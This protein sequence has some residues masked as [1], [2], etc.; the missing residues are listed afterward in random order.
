MTNTSNIRNRAEAALK[1]IFGQDAQFRDGQYEAI[2]ATLTHKRTLVV[3]RT[4]WGK[5]MV[6]FICTRL[7][8]EESKGVTLIVSPLLSLMDNQIA[9]AEKAGLN[10]RILNSKVS[11]DVK[12]DTLNAMKNGDI[13][14]VFT[15]PETLFSEEVQNAVKQSN[16]ALLVIDEAHCISDWGHDFRL[17][18]SRLNKVVSGM[19][20]NVPVL[21]TTATA[22]DRVVADLR[23]QLGGDVFVS[24][25]ALSRESLSIQVLNLE[26]KAERYA[27]ILENLNKLPGS[28]IIYC[29][30]QD[31]CS[32][33]TAFLTAN[34]I[35][36]LPYHNGVSQQD[37]DEAERL[38]FNNRI[39]VLVATV[40][41]GMGYDKSD[42]SFIIHYQ[43]PSNI[44]SYYQQIGRAG[45]NI[46]RAY[47]FLMY[48]SEDL[49]I[50]DFFIESAFPTKEESDAVMD[51]ITSSETALSAD[52]MAL[53]VNL[54]ER[55]ISKALMFLENEEYV[56]SENK[57]YYPTANRY[58]YNHI[59]Y[60]AVTAVRR[61]EQQQMQELLTTDKCYA[62]FVVNCLDDNTAGDC[63][64][65]ANCLGYE[66]FP[67]QVSAENI[68]K[69]EKYLESQILPIL[70]RKR[71]PATAV[72]G[73]TKIHEQADTGLCLTRYGNSGFGK[74]VREGKYVTKR[75]SD[76]LVEKSA[77]VL[78]S[79]I[80][81]NGIS[82][83][84]YVPS[85]RSGIVK[86]LAERLAA[87]LGLPVVTLLEKSG[88]CQQKEMENSVYQCANAM[89]S[90]NVVSSAAVPERVLLVDD[91]VDSRWT[92]TV[93]ASKL[94]KQ[95]ASHV[96]PF[97][98]AC[99]AKK[100]GN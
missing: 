22:N 23:E 7:L 72:S 32:S 58:T 5:S 1:S 60:E 9:S 56:Y 98:L 94:L 15:T 45:R 67:S 12:R 50:Q 10:S 85:L 65:C 81:E 40:K 91:M 66:E 37:N 4:G 57:R 38:F 51:C 63:G 92:F 100:E 69:A 29:L 16:I 35:S 76:R 33:L 17:E 36:A 41:L 21:A 97:A 96:Y 99:S 13:D 25:G 2:E 79:F 64:L 27:W 93:C 80:A 30:T 83:I 78:G 77:E 84:T 59:R 55:R 39:K 90:F 31:D 88:S 28:G 24:R 19:L 34:G 11:A 62:R 86:D 71:W 47:T 3:Q 8:R 49:K 46:D 26:S 89:E 54:P 18:Y 73:Q 42:V 61:R 87:R 68:E 20:P 14:I 6:Y 44:V 43:T 52:K 74:L 95:G 75:F 70:P 82:A 48:G 53:H